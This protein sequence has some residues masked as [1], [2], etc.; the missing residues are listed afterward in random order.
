MKRF[1]LLKESLLATVMILIITFSISYIPI[2]FEFTKPIR[3]GFLG[4]DIYDLY[5]SGKHLKN[6]TR[7][8]NIVIVEIGNDRATIADQ[9]ILI[10]KYSPAVIGIDAIFDKEGEPLENIKLLQAIQQSN[11]I[12]FASK[13]DIDPVTGRP[14]FFHNFFEEKDHLYQSGYIK[15]W[16]ASFR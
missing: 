2:K 7:D 13:Y 5:Y 8:T 10:Q 3:Q 16:G 12:I 6:T 4:F 1:Y 14:A 9:I 11:N 15:Y